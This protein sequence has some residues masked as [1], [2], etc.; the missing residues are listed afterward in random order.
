[1]QQSYIN[2]LV[3]RLA[4][5]N[6]PIPGSPE[7][8]QQAGMQQTSTQYFVQD[9]GRTMVLMAALLFFW[10]APWHIPTMQDG[11]SSSQ[12][13]DISSSRSLLSTPAVVF[14]MEGWLMFFV[15]VFI[16]W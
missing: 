4:D 10:Y 16:R 9:A 14:Q 15:W 5:H 2:L 7:D 1:M 6:I 8:S 11:S 13:L 12:V 3:Q